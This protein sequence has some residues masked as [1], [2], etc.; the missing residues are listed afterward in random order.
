VNTP[1]I[2][3]RKKVMILSAFI[4]KNYKSFEYIKNA[5]NSRPVLYALSEIVK[6]SIK[7]KIY[8]QDQMTDC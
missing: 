5:K 3:D 7:L 8:L 4:E 6:Q 1:S 2:V